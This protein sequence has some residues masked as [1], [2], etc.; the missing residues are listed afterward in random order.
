MAIYASEPFVHVIAQPPHTKHAS[1]TNHAYVYP[2]VDPRTGRL[3]VLSAIDNLGKGAAGQAIQC[4]NVM[5]GLPETLGLD[6][7]GLYP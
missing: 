5:D 7:A 6:A 4:A 2:L 1:G 3:I